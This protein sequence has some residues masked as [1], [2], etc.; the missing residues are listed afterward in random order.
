MACTYHDFK[1]SWE[2][3]WNDREVNKSADLQSERQSKISIN[4]K[5]KNKTKR[6]QEAQQA[7]RF[8]V[9]KKRFA[10]NRGQKPNAV[11]GANKQK[12]NAAGR[13]TQMPWCANREWHKEQQ[14]Y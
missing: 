3:L 9:S 7:S 11:Q 8:V 13:D 12:C 6:T 14:E 10:T 2:D 5:K 1:E 4:V